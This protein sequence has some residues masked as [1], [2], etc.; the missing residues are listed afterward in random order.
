MSKNTSTI[1][2]DILFYILSYILE[3]RIV[4]VFETT[5][6]EINVY[7]FDANTNKV[8]EEDEIYIY[9]N[10][11]HYSSLINENIKL[12]LNDNKNFNTFRNNMINM[13][14][15]K[16]IDLKIKLKESLYVDGKKSKSKKYKSKKYKSKKSKSK[17][18]KSKKSKSKKK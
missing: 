14:P 2:S 1:V 16:H 11:A 8:K 13:I 7:T 18:Y 17:K 6:N 15:S 10:G 4:L 9:G 5:S 3:I 12:N